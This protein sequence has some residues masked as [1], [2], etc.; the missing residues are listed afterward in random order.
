MKPLV[1]SLPKQSGH[2]TDTQLVYGNVCLSL[3]DDLPACD[4]PSLSNDMLLCG[5]LSLS[6]AGLPLWIRPRHK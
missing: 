2:L 5:C 3:S 4:C 6:D 1:I